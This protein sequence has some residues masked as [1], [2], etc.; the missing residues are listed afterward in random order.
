MNEIIKIYICKTNCQIVVNKLQKV[1]TYIIRWQ[2]D[3]KPR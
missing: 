3:E 2:M 1:L